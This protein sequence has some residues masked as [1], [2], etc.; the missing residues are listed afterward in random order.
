[1]STIIEKV[2]EQIGSSGPEITERVISRLVEKEVTRRT[3]AVIK[4]LD[5]LDKLEKEGRRIKPDIVAYAEDGS[6]VSQS[7]SKKTL[8]ERNANAA[9]VRKLQAAIG[10]A[11]EANDFSDLFNLVN[12][13]KPATDQG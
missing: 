7:W 1:M 12:D 4:A 5:A 10:K 2:A 9:K 3:E 13:A 11:L 8:D 6:V